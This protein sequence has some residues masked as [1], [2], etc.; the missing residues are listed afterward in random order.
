MDDTT[1]SFVKQLLVRV[2]RKGKADQR[3]RTTE[4]QINQAI[5]KELM[6]FEEL[7]VNGTLVLGKDI[8][9]LKRLLEA[10]LL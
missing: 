5:Q 1:K 3:N 10:A 7:N 8:E 6:L 4:K 9:Q 2:Y